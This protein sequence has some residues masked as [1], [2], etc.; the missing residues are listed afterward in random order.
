[1]FIKNYSDTAILLTQLIYKN[2]VFTWT[3]QCE[4]AFQ[5]LKQIFIEALILIQFDQ[6]TETIVETDSSG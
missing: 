3:D 5:K 6:D 4:Q 2:V 1:M